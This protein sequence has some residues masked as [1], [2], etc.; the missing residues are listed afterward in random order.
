MCVSVCVWFRCIT[1]SRPLVHHFSVQS[2]LS[3][4]ARLILEIFCVLSRQD[5][6]EF[7][8]YADP[9]GISDCSMRISV[10]S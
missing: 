7:V 1:H 10:S 5:L 9:S 4:D 8:K 2:T 3:K 6:V